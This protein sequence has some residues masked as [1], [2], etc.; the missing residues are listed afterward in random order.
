MIVQ[1]ANCIFVIMKHRIKT[2]GIAS[3]IMGGRELALEIPGRTV[4]D[5]RRHL[6]QR[7]PAL[8][9]LKSLFIAVNQNY[10]DEG[11]ELLANDEIAIIPPVSGG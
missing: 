6:L 11:T 5:L 10:A 9:G 3:E 8:E 1:K 4:A 2:F 7:Y